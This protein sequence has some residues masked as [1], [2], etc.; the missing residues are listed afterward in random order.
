[1]LNPPTEVLKAWSW[2]EAIHV[3]RLSSGL[4]NDSFQIEG[5]QRI[6]G[7][8]QR[9]NTAIFNVSVQQD[10]EALT[11][12]LQVRGVP[13]PTVLRT[14]D[15]ELAYQNEDGEVWRALTW[16]GEKT[17]DTL[18]SE[19]AAQSAAHLVARFHGALSD[20]DW[21]FRHQRPSPHDTRKH[22]ANLEA[23]VQ[24]FPAHRLY[25]QVAPVAEA[26]LQGW[27]LLGTPPPLPTRV[28]HGDLKISN[29]RFVGT[30]A[31]ALIDLD[32]IAHGRLDDE[33]GDALRSW[34]NEAGEDSA[35]AHLRLDIFG[36]VIRGYAEGAQEHLP[37]RRE[38]W[39]ALIPG[40]ERIS[41]ELAARFCTDALRESYFGW[42]PAFAS[43]GEHCL[44]RA[45]GQLSLYEAIARHRGAAEKLL[46]Q[47]RSHF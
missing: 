19:T 45:R 43:H 15:G 21:T 31:H 33:L 24:E 9:L 39:E 17:V 28:I 22:I 44:L 6:L 4:I 20:F 34:C 42:D 7:A 2:P 13:T 41:L 37:L 12:H 27:R 30:K 40:W 8:L 25:D 47:F 38:E 32:T 18:A 1:M 23:A 16:V 10:I 29:I 46:Q 11:Q 35:T 5:E 36:A 26:I 14:R 3:K